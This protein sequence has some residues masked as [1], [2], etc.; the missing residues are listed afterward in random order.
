MAATNEDG[1]RR[2]ALLRA[3]A[4]AL[5]ALVMVGTRTVAAGERFEAP[6]PDERVL[7]C[8]Q[9]MVAVDGSGSTRDDAFDRQIRAL[10][11][12][13]RS[14]RLYRAVQDCLP[15]SVAFAV[16]T[17]SGAGEQD[18]CLDWSIVMTADDAHRLADSLET[19]RYLGG[20][21]D[22]GRAIETGLH[23]LTRS[24]FDSFYRIVFVLTNGRTNDGAEA[25]LERYR[26]RA[27]AAGVTVAGYALLPP[28]PDRSNPLFVPDPVGLEGYV[29]EAVSTG[30]RAFSA[31]SRPDDDV[32]NILRSIVEM[33]RQEAG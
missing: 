29:A 33:L 32:E 27:A 5:A 16:T 4:S 8:A 30:P 18:R 2:R 24:P 14:E 10:Q 26:A 12:A 7:V 15:G 28:P 13:F 21:T 1:R 17:W 9:V 20:T 23:T 19:C 11:S 31:H 22:I 3:A 6:R 25:A